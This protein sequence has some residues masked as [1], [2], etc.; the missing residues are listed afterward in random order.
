M[1]GFPTPVEQKIVRKPMG[2]FE[3]A[4]IGVDFAAL[5]HAAANGSAV[6]PSC[7]SS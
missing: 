6:D 4:K 7:K 3:W 5:A 2:V 1:I